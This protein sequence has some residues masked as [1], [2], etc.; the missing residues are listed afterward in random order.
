MTSIIPPAEVWVPNS[1]N[2]VQVVL[3]PIVSSVAD[4]F[5]LR[6]T[7]MISMSL[8]PFVGAAIAPTSAN[9]HRVIGA[10]IMIGVGFATVPLAY[11]IPSEV[12]PRKWRPCEFWSQS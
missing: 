9:I 1:V 2:L 7:L 10:Q 8:V 4:L 12:F 5:Q 11:S 6:K 3:C